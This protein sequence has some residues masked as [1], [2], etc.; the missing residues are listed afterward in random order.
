VD[1]LLRGFIGIFETAFPGRVRVCYV[2]GSYADGS[3]VATSDVDVTLVFKEAFRDDEERQRARALCEYCVLLSGVELDAEVTDEAG[4]RRGVPPSFKLAATL[5]YGEDRR[6]N[7]PLV[8]IEQWTRDRM[9]SSYWR[10]AHLFGRPLPVRY[11]V[12]YP[13]P[14][15]EF[16]G[17]DR[18]TVRLSGGS[19]APSTRDLIRLVGWAATALIA[20]K[21]RRYVARK[22]DCHV[23]YRELIGGEHAD[24]LDDIYTQCRGRWQYLIPDNPVERRALRDI[25]ARTLA[26]ENA[27][28]LEY[29]TF[30][31]GELRGADAEG[32]RMALEVL[33][34]APL[35][36]EE[37]TAAERALMRAEDV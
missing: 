30:L 24:L 14:N 35:A 7:L 28:L 2:D 21:A 5:V 16:Y 11:P 34:R 20:R 9:H 22:R 36:D 19:E 10:V 18:R 3:G 17:Y 33:E 25:C 12:D 23:L 26:F 37:V 8:S 1:E 31:L 27:F 32:R 29:R 13:D 4:L 15:A 6:D